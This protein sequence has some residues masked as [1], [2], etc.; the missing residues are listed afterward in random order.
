M[1]NTGLFDFSRAED[2]RLDEICMN[3]RSGYLFSGVAVNGGTL[4]ANQLGTNWM[5]GFG[6]PQSTTPAGTSTI[7][8]FNLSPGIF[9]QAPSVANTST[10]DTAANL[11]ALVN[12][13]SAGAVVGDVI[14][15][16]LVNGSGT[17][18]ITLAA[19]SGGSFDT[20]QANRVIAVNTSRYVFIRLTNVTPGSEA[21]VI[22][23]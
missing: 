20:N 6:A 8:A 3:S 1:A 9:I 2:L 7:S 5:N 12:A 22:Y 16:L 10:F 18:T 14:Q 21:Y 4:P 17:N 23:F 13:R 19:G 15:C 11:V